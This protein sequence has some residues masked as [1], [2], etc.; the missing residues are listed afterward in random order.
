MR[1]RL[2]FSLLPLLL[3][4][5]WAAPAAAQPAQSAPFDMSPERPAATAPERQAPATTTPPAAPPPVAPAPVT[6]PA[7]SRPS[8]E[9][10]PMPAVPAAP[11]A[12]QPP[13]PTPDA[14]PADAVTVAEAEATGPWRRHLLATSTLSLSGE[15]DRRRW[16]VYLTREEAEAAATLRLGYQNTILAAPESS[17]LS[18][19]VNDT[20]LIEEAVASSD[21]VRDLSVPV[22]AGLLRPGFN[23]VTV[24]SS[25]RHRTDCTIASTF[26]LWTE[27]DGARTFLEFDGAPERFAAR[28]LEDI[29]ATGVDANGR[30]S[31]RILVPEGDLSDASGPVLRLAEGLALILGMPNLSVE[32]LQ[33]ALPEP[34]PGHLDVVAG[35]TE[36]LAPVLGALAGPAPPGAS[37][38]FVSRPGGGALLVVSGSNWDEVLAG[39]ERIVA[40]SDRPDLQPRQSVSSPALRAPDAPMIREGGVVTLAELGVPSQEFAGRRFQTQ[41]SLAVPAD[42]FAEAYGEAVLRLDVAYSGEILPGSQITVTV[43]GNIATT[44]PIGGVGGGGVLEAFPLKVTMRHL[45]PGANAIGIEAGLLTR[46]DEVCLPGA[47]S[48]T[49]GRFALFDSSRL[50]IP[51]FARIAR[52]PNLAAMQ[53]TGFPYAFGG[54]V[55]VIA[56]DDAAALANAAEI[57]ARLSFAAGRAVPVDTSGSLA[58]AA[59]GNALFVGTPR[60]IPAGVFAQI[61]VDPAGTALWGGGAPAAE[62]TTSLT[63]ERWREQFGA[64]E[65]WRSALERLGDWMRVTFGVEEEGLRLVPGRDPPFVPG[66]EATL[67][68]GQGPGPAPGSVW[69]VVSA[70]TEE[71]LDAGTAA[72]VREEA[73]TR[74]SGRVTTLDATGAVASVPVG[75][76]EFLPTQPLSLANMR[77]ILANWLSENV[78]S[79]ATLLVVV[80][81]LL[82]LATTAF[83]QFLGRRR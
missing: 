75:A 57:L 33:G 28:R 23:T 76:A 30:T 80:A 3:A 50:E 64:E 43:N 51:T 52:V 21:A 65:G 62:Q 73:W 17:R 13:A 38:S 18:I 49:T 81:L 32:I 4:L 39:A 70:P 29:R 83:V 24:E 46:A 2:R 40:F 47:T 35:P 82:G 8:T 9:P 16:S 42:F 1:A 26:D 6:P 15:I 22:P 48:G 67:L 71:A 7:P 79:Y 45:R 58:T 14:A 41:F 56:G 61:N 60:Q 66:A 12:E 78:L 25:L 63:L 69:T 19:F 36:A 74:L 20:P 5:G 31:L 53:G 34:A 59:A 44:L 77:L 11:P 27:I 55:S 10:A 37:P 68:V 72:L 54:P